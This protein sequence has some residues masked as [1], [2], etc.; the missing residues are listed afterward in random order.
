MM[1]IS[2]GNVIVLLMDMFSNYQ[3]SMMLR[4]IPAAIF[5]GQ[6]WRLVTFIFVPLNQNLLWFAFSVLLYYSLGRTL[7]RE[8]GTVKFTV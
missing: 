7:E 3:F 8:W 2:I 5:Q 4:F 1:I 6:I